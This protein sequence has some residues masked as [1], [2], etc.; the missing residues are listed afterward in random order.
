[1][2][3]IVVMGLTSLSIMFQLYHISLLPYYNVPGQVG[4]YLGYAYFHLGATVVF[5]M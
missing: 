3:M 1:M 2:F 5:A 4:Q